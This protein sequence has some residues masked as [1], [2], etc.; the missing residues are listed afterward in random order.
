MR[1]ENYGLQIGCNADLTLLAGETLAHAVVDI[2]P[3]PLVLKAGKVTARQ[4]KAL[5]E[6]P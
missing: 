1:L 6:M 3:R 4:G 2:A 5:V